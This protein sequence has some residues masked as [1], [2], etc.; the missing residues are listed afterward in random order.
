MYPSHF[1]LSSD[2]VVCPGVTLAGLQSRKFDASQAARA[3][4]TVKDMLRDEMEPI[5]TTRCWVEDVEGEAVPNW[6]VIYAARRKEGD[7]IMSDGFRVRIASYLANSW[8]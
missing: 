2:T 1:I 6:L 3:Q 4:A 7:Q 5:G 8:V